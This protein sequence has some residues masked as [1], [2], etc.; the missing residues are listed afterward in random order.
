V[1]LD[2]APC[3]A[4][5]AAVAF[6][7]AGVACGSTPM[8]PAPPPVAPR[9]APP[10]ATAPAPCTIDGFGAPA[11]LAIDK[12]ALRAGG[13]SP[14]LLAKLDDSAYRY[15]R[16]L[17][18]PF[19]A[20]TCWAFRDIR[21][22]LPEAAVHG[23]AHL[24]QFVVTHGTYGLE[25]FDQ[26]GYGPAIVD[27]VRYAASIHVACRQLG[28][29]CDEGAAIETY[30]N[31]YRA[32]LDR[33]PERW[34]A[35]RVVERLRGRSPKSTSAWLDWAERLMAPLEPAIEAKARK[36]WSRFVALQRD[37]APERPASFYDVERVGSLTMGFG[38]SAEQKFLVRIRGASAEPS[39]DLVLEARAGDTSSGAGCIPRATHGGSMRV[40]MFMAILGQRMPDL[41]GFVPVTSEPDAR[42]FWVQ[43]WDPG[44][45]ELSLADIPSQSDLEEVAK[46]A[47]MQLAGHFWTRFPE[48]MRGH[49]RHAQLLA[50]DATRERAITLARELADETLRE[51]EA[52]RKT[53]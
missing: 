49:Q 47:A 28:D 20:R 17:A 41:F 48:P 5:A 15:F 25:D 19:E 30:F 46:D 10:S 38:S 12:A 37:V 3:F 26:A 14:E 1:A 50:F 44:Y 9:V 24:E 40:L 31:A 33:A 27:L 29:F 52:F 8:R 39:D 7:L 36:G 13:A 34:P 2:R 32:S 18:R 45:A 43:A 53:R 11:S 51:W 6:S 22:R 42:E 21:W 35:P 4:L 16:L 23:D